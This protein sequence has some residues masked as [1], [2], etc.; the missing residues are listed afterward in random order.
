VIL[1]LHISILD[2]VSHLAR[3][4]HALLSPG[5]FSNMTY[6]NYFLVRRA[7]ALPRIVHQV[8]EKRSSWQVPQ[9]FLVGMTVKER[10]SQMASK[11]NRGR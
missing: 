4:A 2:A 9:V 8:K 1:L 10:D 3:S 6:A 7:L 5:Y 11:A